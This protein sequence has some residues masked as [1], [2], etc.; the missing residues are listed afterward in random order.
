M[1]MNL[2]P[3]RP[4]V[5]T[6]TGTLLL[7]EPL[8]SP[9]EFSPQHQAEP[10]LRRPQVWEVPAE[11]AVNFEP[12]RPAVETATGTLLSVVELLPNWPY[13]LPPQHQAEPLSR[14]AQVWTL[15]AEMAVNF[16]PDRPVVDTAMGTLLSVVTPLSPSPVDRE[17]QH[18]AE[19]SS[20]KPQACSPPAPA[21]PT[22]T[23]VNAEPVRPAVETATGTLL[24]VVELL[25]N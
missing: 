6:A 18:Q 20:R 7:V 19:P 22:E 24:S 2:D 15:P 21:W 3:V 4:A 17:P 13:V 14:R 1:E 8:P 11:I 9:L 10:S 12:V 16:E 25:P 23:A 5:E